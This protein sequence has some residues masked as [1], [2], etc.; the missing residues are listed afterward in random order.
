LATNAKGNL[1]EA[2]NE[3]NSIALAG[4]IESDPT[5]SQS[6]KAADAKATGDALAQK[7]PAGYGLG[8][9]SKLLT[10][11]DDLNNIKANGWYRWYMDNAPANA[12]VEYAWRE[13]Q[14][15]RVWTLDGG[16]CLQEIVDMGGNP[17]VAG[18]KIQRV[19]FG[20]IAH[21]WECENPPMF[22][23][24]EYR[25]TERYNGKSVWTVNANLGTCPVGET[26]VETSFSA[27]GI[28][29]WDF[30]EAI[31]ESERNDKYIRTAR[32]NVA[33]GKVR[34]TVIKGSMV[35]EGTEYCQVWYTKD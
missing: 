33:N 28:V 22:V 13:F 1:V 2:I 30:S 5:L 31:F 11:A 15:C 6:G 23:G 24:V 9:E 20:D 14:A 21:P 35:G 34:V 8:V 16:V 10:S 32:A 4:G 25:T 17:A 3:V 27:T 26:P 19:M 12:P 7:A 18:V 29:R